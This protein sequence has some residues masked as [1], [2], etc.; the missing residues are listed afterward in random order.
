MI[1][2]DLECPECAGP[3]LATVDADRVDVDDCTNGEGCEISPVWRER[4]REQA[5][6]YASLRQDDRRHRAEDAAATW[7]MD[8]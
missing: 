4:L 2:V 3:L 8:R 5:E 7:R 1:Y 6:G